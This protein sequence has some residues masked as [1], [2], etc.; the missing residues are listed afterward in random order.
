MYIYVYNMYMQYI[1]IIYIY[2]K[3]MCVYSASYPLKK[4]VVFLNVTII[5]STGVMKTH[6]KEL[7]QQDFQRMK[8]LP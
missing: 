1:H 8:S 3:F 4:S 2:T 6:R 7:C 5:N